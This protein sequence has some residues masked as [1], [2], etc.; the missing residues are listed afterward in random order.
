MESL[1]TILKR[2]QAQAPGYSE[3]EIARRVVAY[4][5]VQHG[6]PWCPRCGGQG[7]ISYRRPIA[8]APPWNAHEAIH[9]GGPCPEC[10]GE[11]DPEEIMRRRMQA[12][13]LDPLWR[14]RFTFSTWDQFKNP[15]LMPLLRQVHAWA[16]EPHQT[17]LLAGPNGTGKTH[18]AIA[19][20]Q[21]CLKSMA[22]RYS[23]VEG[24]LQRFKKT[25]G[26]SSEEFDQVYANWVTI[27]DMLVLDDLG[28]ET[29]GG[30]SAWAYATVENLIA[31]RLAHERHMVITTNG[32][33][34]FS[35]R[36]KSRMSDA[37]RVIILSFDGDDMR[38]ASQGVL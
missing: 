34:R 11:K 33:S 3:A 36:L 12:S 29:R 31:D 7:T 35:E 28:A 6:R 22:V 8:A 16:N 32:V 5:E 19:I 20:A 23:T 4:A 38:P 18:L 13:G 24:L 21:V 2:V 30:D 27:P 10:N 17:L 26:A 37:S 9:Y 1:G 14:T 25:F 15:Q